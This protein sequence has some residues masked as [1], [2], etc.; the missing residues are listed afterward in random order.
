MRNIAVLIVAFF[1]AGCS[2]RPD[3][4]NVDTNFTSQY[5]SANINDNWWQEFKD[6][7]LNMLVDE[8][9]KN[10]I[11]LK[12]A[13]INLEQASLALQNAKADFLPTIDATGDA[14]KAA[15]IGD[16]NPNNSFS[17]NAVLNYEVDLWGRVRNSVAS[18][19]AL[20][21]ASKFDYETSRLAIA[22]SVAKSYFTLVSLKMQESIYLDT[23]KSYTDTMEYRKRQLDAGSITNM[24]YLQSV[25]Q[26]QSAQINLQETRSSISSASNALAILCN[27]SNDE[28]LHS[29]VTTEQALPTAP[30][31][32]AKISSDV[33]LRRPDVASAYENLKSSNALAGVARAA[34]FPTLSLTGLFGFSSN[35][36]DRLVTPTTSLWSLGGSL[37]QNL[38]N[39]NKTSNN[40]DIAKLTQ[41]TKALN[42]EKAV[43]TALGETK[44]ALD[45]RKNAVEI[46]QYSN[47]LLKSQTQIYDLADAQYNAG[48][49]DHITLLDAQRTLLSTKLGN[50]NA[51]LN[52]NNAVVDVY[53][54]FGGGFKVQPTE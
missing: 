15:S 21:N 39:Y 53:K 51:K 22:S 25:A 48:Y 13:Y 20:L 54:A 42:Y 30:Q 41:D 46:L 6:E 10:N 33:L 17:L 38:F 40:V 31:I 8:A 24:V 50:V 3:M 9:L 5:Q 35:E 27:K 19:K 36:L 37:T 12:I 44:V 29:I 47:E 34:Y 49:V 23:L 11:D 7:K 16:K 43:K 32:D 14:K 18:N 1:I 4:P 52:L 45:T 26:V 28:I 2:F